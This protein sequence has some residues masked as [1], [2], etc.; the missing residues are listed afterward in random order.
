MLMWYII[1]PY[2]VKENGF[3]HWSLKSSFRTLRQMHFSM[4]DY[5]Q[6]RLVEAEPSQTKAVKV[7]RQM[8]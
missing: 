5:G 7:D 6:T 8:L 1:L 2:R 3:C 4:L